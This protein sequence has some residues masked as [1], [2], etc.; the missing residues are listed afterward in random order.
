MTATATR[1]PLGTVLD[2]IIPLTRDLKKGLVTLTPRQAR[3]LVDAYYQ[4]QDYRI[5]AANQQRSLTAESEPAE[6]V[7]WLF[8]QMERLEGQIKL[9]L[10]KWSEGQPAGRWAKGVYGIG[11]VLAAGLLAHVDITRCQTVGQ[12]WRFAGLDP[13]SKWLGKAGARAVA[14]EA[15]GRDP[16]EDDAEAIQQII[17]VEQ[18]DL[19][20]EG[21]NALSYADLVAI[22]RLANRK[23]GNLA[24][25]ARD[26]QGRVTRAGI[27]KVLAKR[28]WNAQLKVLTWK[29]GQSFMKFHNRED[30][31][32]GHLYAERKALEQ[33]RNAAGAFADQ[34]AAVIAAGRIGKETEAYKAYS[35][36][37]LPPAH[38]DARARRYAVKLFLAGYHEVAYFLHYGT[39]PP[40]PYPLEHLGH[41]HRIHPAGFAAVPG[42]LEAKRAAGQALPPE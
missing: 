33:E 15:L 38:I 39:L 21:R 19:V 2:P 40:N 23:V 31:V 37:Q 22:S 9:A 3:Y 35:I 5:G 36:G 8:E 25:L 24:R 29:A 28:P 26:E 16:A 14:E 4:I 34:A 1:T 42:L 7:D 11:P 6:V 30:C 20:T 27:L 18:I 17:T 32:Y 41:A 13:S 12:L 10:D